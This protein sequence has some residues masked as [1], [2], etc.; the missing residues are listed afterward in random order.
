MQSKKERVQ[1]ENSST[2]VESRLLVNGAVVG[3]VWR[4]EVEMG[5][6]ERWRW[7]ACEDSAKNKH[8]V[9]ATD[10]PGPQ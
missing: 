7:E 8:N 5:E 3:V 10:R 9:W 2:R 1:Y 4:G 6:V